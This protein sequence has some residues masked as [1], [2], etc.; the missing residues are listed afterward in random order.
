LCPGILIV[1]VTGDGGLANFKVMQQL[2][3]LP[4]VL[5]SDHGD[6]VP[7]DAQRAQSDIFQIADGGG[8]QIKNSVQALQSVPF[9][10]AL[11]LRNGKLM[12]K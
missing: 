6:L 7:Q 12:N 2:L 11:R 1:L 9:E 5:T 10:A 3:G 4:R 8:H